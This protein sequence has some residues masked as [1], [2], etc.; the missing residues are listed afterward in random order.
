MPKNQLNGETYRKGRVNQFTQPLK[1]DGNPQQFYRHSINEAQD[2]FELN[3][4]EICQMYREGYTVATVAGRFSVSH[5]TANRWKEQ[6]RTLAMFD[7]EQEP[8]TV[9]RLKEAA[10]A[11]AG[12]VYEKLRKYDE[13]KQKQLMAAVTAK[14]LYK[15]DDM[16]EKGLDLI[17]KAMDKA[18]VLIEKTKDLGTVA[19]L[20]S[21]ILPYVAAHKGT[22]Q[23]QRREPG[24]EERRAL[25]VQNIL[26]VYHTKDP[27]QQAAILE[28]V[29]NPEPS[30]FGDDEEEYEQEYS[31]YEDLD[32]STKED[33]D[34]LD[35]DDIL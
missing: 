11:K 22:E 30:D 5:R 27:K 2:I 21:A 4:E 16:R 33:P 20:M 29:K 14:A 28:A 10:V 19:R 12:Q 23:K 9:R 1:K 8:E 31:E 24:L 3:R 34:Y 17:F 13:K 35:D 7:L 32:T 6:Y 18:E 25:F 26:N 15:V